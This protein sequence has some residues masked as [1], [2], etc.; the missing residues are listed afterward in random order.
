MKYKIELGGS[1]FEEFAT[2]NL[3][4]VDK[5]L[6]IQ[7]I[8]DGGNK[9]LLITRPRR[10]GKT[11]NMSMLDYFFSIP[12]HDDASIDEEKHQEK[13]NIFSR[14]NISAYADTMQKYCGQ[15]PTIF[16]SFKDI[17]KSTY[18]AIKEGIRA[19]ICQLYTT[20]EYLLQSQ[21]LSE[22][23]K[24]VIQKYISMDFN[25][26]ALDCSIKVLSEMLFKHFGQKTIILIDEYD[27]SMNDWYSRAIADASTDGESNQSLQQILDLFRNIFSAA[28][29]DNNHLERGVI[30][31][32]L[33]I[34]KAS[35]FSGLN[36]LGEDCVLDHRY[37]QHFG[38]TEEE[39][40]WLLH[41]TNMD[42]DEVAAQNLKDWYNGYNIGGITIY[43]PW[44]IMNYLSTR[45]ELKAYWV[46]TASTTLFENALILDQFKEEI[47]NLIEGKTVNAIADPKMVFVDIKSSPNAFYNL[48]LFSG[49]LTAK[50][51]TQGRA[52]TYNCVVRIPNKEVLEVFELSILQWLKNK[53]NIEPTEYN[54][55]M[56]AFLAG[57]LEFF[58]LKLKDFIKTAVS[59]HSTAIDKAES[60]YNGVMTTLM[61][62]I[63]RSSYIV[64]QERESGDGRIDLLVIPKSNA[65]HKNALILEFK[66]MGK[67]SGIQNLKDIAQE[68]LNQINNKSYETRVRTYEGVDQI[69]K[70]GLAFCGKNVEIAWE[71]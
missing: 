47:H 56:N 42:R 5:T 23:N 60:F 37:A 66:I 30:T 40:N 24:T 2:N 59:F 3:L 13:I 39:V 69:I 53:F 61:I 33:R 26:A 71:G 19:V 22:F 58:F 63:P 27:T 62:L 18:D 36:N 21:K 31:G 54:D 1:N 67:K 20:H 46:G 17:K 48:L 14:M 49:Y 68:G 12:V 25:D 70:V 10:W 8:I 41:E 52:A 6:L 7:D 50:E 55:F 16:V 65:R 35:L 34:A 45:G 38:F 51:I 32:I 4:L 9:V 28:L 44:S 11:L 15:Y 29:K 57:D 43:N 64:E